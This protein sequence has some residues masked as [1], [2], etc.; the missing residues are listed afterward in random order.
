MKRD[1]VTLLPSHFG[2]ETVHVV[3]RDGFALCGCTVEGRADSR[4]HGIVCKKCRTLALNEGYMVQPS[5]TYN[6]SE[7][8]IRAQKLMASLRRKSA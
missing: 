7:V 8:T 1:G 3:G 5:Y 4:V 2:T 6:W